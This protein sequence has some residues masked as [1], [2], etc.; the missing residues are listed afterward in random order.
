VSV[1]AVEAPGRILL[2]IF[3]QNID[4]PYVGLL[5]FLRHRAVIL[6]H[7]PFLEMEMEMGSKVAV[8]KVQ[9]C[10]IGVFAITIMEGDLEVFHHSEDHLVLIVDMIN[11]GGVLV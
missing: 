10:T 3:R 5:V 2:L 4:N 6:I 11:A 7:T 1:C 9:E 8:K